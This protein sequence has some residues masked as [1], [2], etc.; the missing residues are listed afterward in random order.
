MNPPLWDEP[1]FLEYIKHLLWRKH[2]TSFNTIFQ[3]VTALHFKP[4]IFCW[5]SNA[6]AV[7][8]NRDLPTIKDM[9]NALGIIDLY[10][11]SLEAYQSVLRKICR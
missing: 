10:F 7:S 6:S 8:E 1:M 2:L 4:L 3:G 9:K 5:Y 11:S